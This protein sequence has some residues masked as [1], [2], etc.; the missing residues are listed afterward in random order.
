MMVPSTGVYAQVVSEPR[1]VDGYC[2]ATTFALERIKYGNGG[3]DDFPDPWV[4]CS[5]KR[6]QRRSAGCCSSEPLHRGSQGLMRPASGLS[7]VSTG[8]SPRFARTSGSIPSSRQLAREETHKRT[9][10]SALHGTELSDACGRDQV[11]LEVADGKGAEPASLIGSDLE[12]S[13]R[14]VI[15]LK[16]FV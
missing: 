6:T 8:S 1:I 13:S 4:P 9:H 10:T 2:V 7:P 12:R 5:E 15:Q 3:G 14:R 16:S 11:R